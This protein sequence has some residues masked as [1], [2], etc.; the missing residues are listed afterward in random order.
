MVII[1]DSEKRHTISHATGA[2]GKILED[3]ECTICK[4]MVNDP[5]ECSHCEQV[6]C[7]HCLTKWLISSKTC[8]T[9]RET[10]EVKSLNRKLRS[11]LE[12]A[13]VKCRNT[14]CPEKELMTY[15]D[16]L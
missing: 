9:C 11:I 15:K 12:K 13:K 8:P 14:G 6:Y 2:D 5:Q 4:G 1:S 16:L 10:F 7:Q 3:F